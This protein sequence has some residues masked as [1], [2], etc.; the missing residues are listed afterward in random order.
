LGN[1]FVEVK[2]VETLLLVASCGFAPVAGSAQ[3]N[4]DTR[5]IQESF[6]KQWATGG[7]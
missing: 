6:S 7:L 1:E 4:R 3:L 5:I 2:R